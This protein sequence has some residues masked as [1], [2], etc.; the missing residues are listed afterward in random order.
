MLCRVLNLFNQPFEA[1]KPSFFRDLAKLRAFSWIRGPLIGRFKDRALRN[2]WKVS[3]SISSSNWKILTLFRSFGKLSSYAAKTSA[4][5]LSVFYIWVLLT[6]KIL[7]SSLWDF[8]SLSF[9]CITITFSLI[10]S[11]FG[12][13]LLIAIIFIRYCRMY[14]NNC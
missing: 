8:P 6:P 4:F 2:Y 3:E 13:F 9:C 12:F 10:E 7:A 11:S 1:S 5:L 14:L